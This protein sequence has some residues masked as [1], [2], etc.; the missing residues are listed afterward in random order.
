MENG[1]KMREN[2]I[3]WKPK[4]PKLSDAAK[5]AKWLHQYSILSPIVSFPSL[6]LLNL[7]PLEN[8]GNIAEKI[9]KMGTKN[10][11]IPGYR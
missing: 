10:A 5:I 2:S 9:H 4:F 8:S 3:K 1:D 11:K 6:L 7:K